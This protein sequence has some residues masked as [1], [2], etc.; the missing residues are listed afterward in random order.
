M[1]AL[2]KLVIKLAVLLIPFPLAIAIGISVFPKDFFDAEYGWYR[3]HQEYAEGQDEPC[4][5][6]IMGDS[7]A[8]VACRPALLSDDTYNF[9]LQG[10]T[11]IEEYYSLRTYLENHDAPQYL[12]CM[13]SPWYFVSDQ[14]FWNRYVYFHLLDGGEL[15]DIGE[16]LRQTGD[17]SAL[18]VS[19]SGEFRKEAVL[20]SIYAP[21]KYSTV[22][23]KN[24]FL[25]LFGNG[26]REAYEVNYKYVA[27]N[28]GQSQYSAGQD[29][30]GAV[31]ST[32]K[33]TA[34]S[35]EFIDSYYRDQVEQLFVGQDTFSPSELIDRYFRALI[36]L[37]LDNDIRFIFQ[38]PPQNAGSKDGIASEW[39]AGFEEYMNGI[40][41]DY[42]EIRMDAAVEWR[43]SE[44]FSDGF[45]FN[46]KGTERYCAGLREKYSYVFSNE[47]VPS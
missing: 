13:N 22:F 11:P 23:L 47:E 19:S 36:Q 46:Q 15:R 5:V 38:S 37:C 43:E 35:R 9:S 4:R 3:Q 30:D 8:K 12:I 1:R 33:D 6:M 24:L 28:R 41:S 40:Q 17:Y 26:H 31:V 21:Q 2:P 32:D 14:Y 25:N 45:H 20:Y 18:G 27:A 44:D 42:P 10:A 29:N 16:Q 34:L 39:I 7:A